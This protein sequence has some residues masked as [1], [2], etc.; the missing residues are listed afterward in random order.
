MG[1]VFA[2]VG[3]LEME[4]HQRLDAFLPRLRVA[5]V[6]SGMSEEEAA[7]TCSAFLV[8]ARQPTI[9]TIR[10]YRDAWTLCQ[11]MEGILRT[12]D[13]GSE[14]AARCTVL[15]HAIIDFQDAYEEEHGH[16]P[17]M[18]SAPHTKMRLT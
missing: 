11:A 8:G 5:L 7:F 14:A 4:P 16:P 3:V 12:L 1:K 9:R 6:R 18:A 13:D 10:E 17:A 15:S 2:G